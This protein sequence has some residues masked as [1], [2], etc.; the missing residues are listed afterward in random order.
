MS[1][2]TDTQLYKVEQL[3]FQ[4]KLKEAQLKLKHFVLKDDLSNNERLQSQLLKSSIQTNLGEYESSLQISEPVFK[5]SQE[6]K[7][8]HLMLDSIISMVEALKGIGG[9]DKGMNLITQGLKII[10]NLYSTD[11]I[12]DPP[13]EIDLRKASLL[14]H[15]GH[16]QI[17]T[18]DFDHAFE[19]CQQGLTIFER[20]DYIQGIANAHH[21]LGTIYAAKGNLEQALLHTQKGLTLRER[22]DH[23]L[24]IA[25]SLNNLGA[26]YYDKGELDQALEYH[27]RSLDLKEAIGNKLHIALSLNNIGEVYQQKGELDLAQSHLKRSLALGREIGNKRYIAYALDHIGEVYQ[28]KRELDLAIKSHKKSLALGEELWNNL[29]ISGALFCLI[30][31]SIDMDSLELAKQY[32]NRLKE[33]NEQQQNPIIS[34]R[35]RVAEAIILKTS[36]RSR[37]RGKSENILAQVVKEPIINHEV[38]VDALLNLCDLLLVELRLSDDPAVMNEIQAHVTRLLFIADQQHSHWLLAETFVLRSK[39]VLV[40]GEIKASRRF[41]EQ[42]Q[43]LAEERGLHRLAMQISSDHD[44]LLDQLGNWQNLIDRNASMNERFEMARLSEMFMRMVQKKAETIPELHEEDPELLLI[45]DAVSGLTVF[46]KTFHTNRPVAEHLIGSFLT[47][48]NAVL[49]ETFAEDGIIERIKHA[50]YTLL[51]DPVKPF[52]ICY[53][54]K[55]ASYLALKRLNQFVEALQTSTAIWQELRNA[56]QVGR[57]VPDKG[58]MGKLVSELFNIVLK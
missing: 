13:K 32:L 57:I 37:S 46:S 14:L 16:I 17:H 2:H 25:I 8:S 4:G 56:R 35:Y 26:I 50:D 19:F 5:E 38:T 24:S 36:S 49:Q 15:K 6:L 9:Y 20:Y 39:L 34:Q 27:S 30:S 54:F 1:H 33:L 52:L 22:L 11:S 47:A 41:L 18:G 43:H 58:E 55:G 51:L 21:N 29:T 28:Q 44:A 12:Q 40:E 48:I 7:N 42:A 53:A 23:K 3:I 45:I 10:E 31:V